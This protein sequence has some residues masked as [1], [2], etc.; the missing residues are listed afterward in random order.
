MEEK[1]RSSRVR[2]SRA[3]LMVKDACMGPR[4]PTTRTR[5]IVLR[6]RPASAAEVMSVLRRRER[7]LRR[8][9]ATSSATLPCPIMIASGPRARSGARSRYSGSPLYQPTKARAE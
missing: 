7:S 2:S 3:S 6:A 9:R 1:D 5:L 8:M 4:R